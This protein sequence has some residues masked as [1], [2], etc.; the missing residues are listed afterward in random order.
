MNRRRFVWPAIGAVVVALGAAAVLAVPR[1]PDRGNGV[2][3]APVSKGPVKV[4]IYATGELRA[5]RTMTLVTPPVGG[6]L[7]I[8]QMKITGQPVKNGEVVMEFDPADQQYALEQAKSELAEAE[9]EIVKMKADADVQKAQDDVALLTARFDVRRG[10]LD[11]SGNE[12]I[13][14][15]E[16]QKNVLT[17]EEA[18][19]RLAQLEEDVKSRAATNQASLAV[20]QEKRNKAMLGMQ[21]AQQLI[22]SLVLKAPLDGTISIKE[23]RD[24]INFFGPGMVIPEYREGDSVWPGRPVA[25]VM[26][27]GKM[28]VRAKIAE[29]DRANLTAGQKAV[30][31]V[32][33]LPGES[34]GVTVGALSGLAS[35]AQWFE[36]ATVTRL[37]DVTFQFD[38]PDQ[39][40][41]AGASVRVIIQGKEIPDAL[42]VPRQAVL[43]KNGKTHVFVKTGDRF[44]QREVK[45]DNLTESRAVI[46]GIAEGTEVALTDPTVARQTSS[47][48]SPTL[49]AAGGAR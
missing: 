31:E 49:P 29:S 42:H 21:R 10:Q 16:A 32:D 12:L 8:V 14:A 39:R 6:M 15:V 4:T 19:R 5:G 17:L 44:E 13:P 45:V 11:A 7:R 30:V 33:S 2:P 20:V 3:T 9:Q 46:T 28:E 36:S 41:K 48:G 22:D 23:N 37:F 1:L 43:E 35:R 24:G 26:E 25:D 47:S 18:K 40:L 27:A 34:F 38:K